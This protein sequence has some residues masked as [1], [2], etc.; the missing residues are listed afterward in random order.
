MAEQRRDPTRLLLLG[1]AD[2]LAEACYR[3]LLELGQ[4]SG[5]RLTSSRAATILGDKDLAI[6][7]GFVPT[8]LAPIILPSAWAT[9]IGWW[10]ALGHEIGHDF[11]ASVQGFSA[12][13]RT[14]CGLDGK[15]GLA[16][17][18]AAITLTDVEAAYACWGEE[19]FADVFG[20]L[21]LG[22]A[23]VT[24]MIWIFANPK[25]PE[26][27][28][29]IRPVA[30]DQ[31]FSTY[32]EH[33]P[34]HLRVVLMCWLLGEIGFPTEAA[35]LEKEWR[36]KH[37]NPETLLVPTEAR[38]WY[39]VDEDPYIARGRELVSTLYLSP[40]TTLAGRALRS[41]PGLDLGPREHQAA[42]DARDSFLAGRESRT[43]DPRSLIAGAVLAW[44]ERP[45]LAARVLEAARATVPAVGV[46][47]RQL[48]LREARETSAIAGADGSELGLSAWRDAFAFGEVIRPPRASRLSR[49]L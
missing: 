5:L 9:E 37:G 19:L 17:P 31:S 22:A 15:G 3:P 11:Y 10:P 28:T 6:F 1:D 20:T 43:R 49:R 40:F 30:V 34:A 8:G 44:K 45:A 27:V 16:R 38:V 7:V 14:T 36:T 42:L 12:E 26:S 13:M 24:T 25:T 47:R 33:P 46:S 2:A 41:I 4:G 48:R 32:E 35:V 21:M 18:L 39:R 23:Y 29:A